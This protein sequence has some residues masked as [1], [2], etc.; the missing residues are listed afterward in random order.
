MTNREEELLAIL[1][2]HAE[3]MRQ[4]DALIAEQAQY[5]HDGDDEVSVAIRDYYA[6]VNKVFAPAV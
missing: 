3:R 4:V 2:T 5:S 6:N 1:K